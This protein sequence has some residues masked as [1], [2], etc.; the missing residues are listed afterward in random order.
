M[1]A[2]FPQTGFKKYFSFGCFKGHVC[3]NT[4][5]VADY[6]LRSLLNIK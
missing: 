1:F 2:D 5:N 6:S 3:L 4:T